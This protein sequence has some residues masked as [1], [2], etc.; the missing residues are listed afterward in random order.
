MRIL[1]I[2]RVVDSHIYL[3]PAEHG[4]LP[5]HVQDGPGRQIA[6]QNVMVFVGETYSTVHIPVEQW[7]SRNMFNISQP[8]DS[9]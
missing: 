3:V 9:Q 8:P 2:L 1:P 6:Q 4:R 7:S 5:E